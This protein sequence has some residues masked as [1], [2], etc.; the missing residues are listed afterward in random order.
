MPGTERFASRWG[1]IL[2]AL[3]MAIGTG[4]MWRFPRIVATNGGGT[5]LLPWL[6]FLATWSIPL[7]I[8]ESAMGKAARRGTVGT[9]TRLVGP[10]STWQ[11]AFVG[12]CTMGIGFYYSVVA[13][14]C[15]KYLALSLSGGFVC[16]AQ[17]LNGN[18]KDRVWCGKPKGRS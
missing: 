14:W 9:F 5:F 15:L 3:G 12:F 2:A 7:L 6:V 18:C 10:R 4:N 8:V 17:N 16:G 11:G 13:G 1:L